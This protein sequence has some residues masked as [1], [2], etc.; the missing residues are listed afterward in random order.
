MREVAKRRRAP[1]RAPSPVRA[2]TRGGERHSVEAVHGGEH[3][4]GDAHSGERRR[5]EARGTVSSPPPPLSS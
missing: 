3:S 4:P 2:L 1:S 5:S